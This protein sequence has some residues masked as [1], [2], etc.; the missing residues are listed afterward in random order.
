MLGAGVAGGTAARA[1]RALGATVKIFDHDINRLRDIQQHSGQPVFTSN[2]HEN[3]L[4]NAFKSA[5][6]VIGSMQYYHDLNRICL[7]EDYVTLM[8]KGAIIIDIS[9]GQGRGCFETSVLKKM[10]EKRSMKNMACSI[11]APPISVHA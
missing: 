10:P 6:V 1:A 8:K 3:V 4:K 9:V 7:S 11:T 2:F 5:D